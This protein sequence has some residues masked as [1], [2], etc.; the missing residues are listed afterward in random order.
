MMVCNINRYI[1][2]EC[3]IDIP[4]KKRVNDAVSSKE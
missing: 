3:G 2:F 4:K 1:A